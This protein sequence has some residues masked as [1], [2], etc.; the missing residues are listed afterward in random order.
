MRSTIIDRG[1]DENK[2]KKLALKP[3]WQLQIKCKGIF[4]HSHGLFKVQQ[5]SESQSFIQ[6]NI[7]NFLCS[8][9]KEWKKWRLKVGWTEGQTYRFSF[10]V[11]TEYIFNRLI[12]PAVKQHQGGILPRFTYFLSQRFT[13]AWDHCYST[14]PST[15][16]ALQK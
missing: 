7:L 3:C 9:R 10:P 16:L 4:T 11:T 1:Q 15:K 6:Q 8:M 12:T 13:S 2:K 5:I 14:I